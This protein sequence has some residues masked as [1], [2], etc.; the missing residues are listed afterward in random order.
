VITEMDRQ[1]AEL[2]AELDEAGLADETIVFYYSDHGGILPRGKRYLHDTGTHVPLVV[3]IPPA[4]AERMGQ[5]PGTQRDDIVEFIDLAPTLL[6][7]AG[8]DVPSAMKGRD[9]FAKG[10]DDRGHS[11]LLY[12]DRFDEAYRMERGLVSGEYRYIHNFMPHL[13]GSPQNGYPYGIE[14][15][16]ALRNAAEDGLL[17]GVHAQL[18]KAP[19]PASQLF[20][21]AS[22]PWEVDNLASDPRQADRLFLMRGRLQQMMRVHRDLGVIPEPFWPELAQGESIYGYAHAPE[23]PWD[24]VIGAAFLASDGRA[25]NLEK[26]I[27]LVRHDHPVV[28]YWGIYGCL[29]LGKKAA[30]VS[31]PLT[32]QLDDPHAANRIT[33]LHALYRIEPA[34]DLVQQLVREATTTKSD[35]AAALALFTLYQLEQQSAVSEQELRR[36][37][38]STEL[39]YAA[40]WANRFLGER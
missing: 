25:E 15:W 36:L 28:R 32:R 7:L 30:G 19:Q 11:A 1:V 2:L 24:D 9:I 27:A 16:R 13:P 26:L 40:R 35:P 38:E 3:R 37:A 22:D 6:T 31:D 10:D 29:V 34:P 4:L 5:S 17:S 8:V 12:A 20:H 23:F 21:T 18:W 33:A 39:Q 14:S